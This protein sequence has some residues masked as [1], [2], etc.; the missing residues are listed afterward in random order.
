MNDSGS[1]IMTSSVAGLI[2]FPGLGAYVTSKHAIVG[3]MRTTALEVAS[4]KIRVNS[5]HRLMRPE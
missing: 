5:I 4:K 1:I 3:I 2:G